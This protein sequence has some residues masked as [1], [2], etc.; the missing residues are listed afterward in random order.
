MH[1]TLRWLTIGFV[2]AG[3]LFGCKAEE[4]RA[5]FTLARRSTVY[6]PR[7]SWHRSSA[8]G[9]FPRISTATA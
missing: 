3:A 9:M 5:A 1:G 2:C 8:S 7:V 6:G 4:P